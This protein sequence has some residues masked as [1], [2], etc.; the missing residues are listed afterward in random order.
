[1]SG[2][3]LFGYGSLPKAAMHQ[4]P[5][6]LPGVRNCVVNL[7]D[8]QPGEKVAVIAEETCDPVVV[9]AFRVVASEIEAVDVTTIICKPFSPAGIDPDNPS[10]AVVQAYAASDT[11]FILS[12][13]PD[14]HSRKLPGAACKW[15]NTKS[16]SLYQMATFDM[17]SSPA[18][19]FPM[20]IMYLIM[21]KMRDLVA[22]KLMRVTDDLGTEMLVQAPDNVEDLFGGVRGYPP[23]PLTQ[24]R[25]AHFPPST[26]GFIPVA[27]NGVFYPSETTIIGDVSGRLKVTVENNYVTAIEGDA[28]AK[29][30]W[31]FINGPGIVPGPKRLVECMW[32]LNPKIRSKSATAT[33]IERERR[34]GVLH[35]GIATYRHG[36]SES[37]GSH[38]DC[39]IPSPRIWI[40]GELIF[41]RG[42]F[43]LLRD[44][45]VYE[46]AKQFGDPE[47][48][49]TP[50]QPL[51]YLAC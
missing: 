5:L 43:A 50:G 35:F 32:G 39:Y 7:A 28:E 29:A 24:G 48:L 22:G 41:D 26:T 44:R 10:D 47:E 25:R 42:D 21:K 13:Y 36:T 19:R 1:M 8:V 27:A 51:D 3:Q 17:L 23:R 45:E 18:A 11:S 20:P 34:A 2:S 4:L 37:W 30:L 49:L 16:V 33:M 6:L 14:N 12:W 40:D 31:A 46:L 9:E 15:Y 38:V